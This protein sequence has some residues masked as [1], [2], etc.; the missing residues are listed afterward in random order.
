MENLSRI[1]IR[2]LHLFFPF[3]YT[4]LLLLIVSLSI[5]LFH[6]LRHISQIFILFLK[7]ITLSLL[8]IKQ[9]H[10]LT[11]ITELSGTEYF[12]SWKHL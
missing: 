6:L 12:A 8:Y 11:C 1:I 10:F 9:E 7:F 3:V 5:L 2:L 4:Y